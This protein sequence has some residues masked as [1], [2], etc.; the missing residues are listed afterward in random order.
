MIRV[1]NAADSKTGLFIGLKSGHPVTEEMLFYR[2][3][4]SP[5]EKTLLQEHLTQYF[6]DLFEEVRY[7]SY[8]MGWR[9]AKSKK[10]A[11]RDFFPGVS[12]V[13]QWEKNQAGL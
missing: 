13:T 9:D 10:R 5:L 3:C 2:E 4:A 6:S 7:T 12:E 11:K 8:V 1:V